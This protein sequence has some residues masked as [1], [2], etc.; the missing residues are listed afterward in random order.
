MLRGLTT[1]LDRKLVRAGAFLL[2]A[3]LVAVAWTVFRAAGQDY[4]AFWLHSG[5]L[6]GLATAAF[7]WAWGGLD[8]NPGLVSA[9]PL[10]YAGAALQVAGVPLVA[11]G[12]HMRRDNH[13]RPIPARDLVLVVPLAM[14]FA[15]AVVAWLLLIAPAQYFGFLLAGAPSRIALA[16]RYRLFALIDGARVRYAEGVALDSAGFR[17]EDGWWDASMRDRPVT[18]A[19]AF[20]AAALLVVDILV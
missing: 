15:V 1:R 3:G 14:V 9:D 8:R 19:S 2:L 16:S 11:F 10:D 17:K 6:I 13:D 7:G 20:M 5:P 12:G 4:W 18:V